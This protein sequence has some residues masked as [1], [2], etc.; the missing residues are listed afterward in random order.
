MAIDDCY[1]KTGQAPIRVRW[2]DINKGDEKNE[3]Y[4]SRLVAQEVNRDNRGD[5]F[6]SAS[7]LEANMLLFN[8]A[9]TEGVG[10]ELGKRKHDMKLYFCESRK[11]FFQ[12]D[13]RTEV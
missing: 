5:L 13:A 11:A 6:A 7:P 2:L 1:E 8:P 12:A 4:R 10:Y 9:V 3:E